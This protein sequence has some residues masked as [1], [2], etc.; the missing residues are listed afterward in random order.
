MRKIIQ[1]VLIA[2]TLALWIALGI[3]IMRQRH[4]LD[5]A[6]PMR[7]TGLSFGYTC[8]TQFAPLGMLG[9]TAI[10]GCILGVMKRCSKKPRVGANSR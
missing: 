1:I 4:L 5:V 7:D 8:L 6:D 2:G 9:L 3:L 10:V